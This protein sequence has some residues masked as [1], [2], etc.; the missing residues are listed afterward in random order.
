MT[1]GIKR[2][3]ETDTGARA[4]QCC[5]MFGAKDDFP[6]DAHMLHDSARL[7]GWIIN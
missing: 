3:V 2:K 1:H 4:K 6:Q 7:I 5:D